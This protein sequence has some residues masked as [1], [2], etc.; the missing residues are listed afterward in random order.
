MK[1]FDK[2]DNNS[3][4]RLSKFEFADIIK[5]LTRVTGATFPK[6]P[7]IDDI[8]S[9]LDTDGDLTISREEFRHLTQSLH[10]LIS[11]SGIRLYYKG[12][13]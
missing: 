13:I 6:R 8:F 7:D 12:K 5:Y 3:D 9:Y 4:G 2:Y 11:S 1:L 10:T